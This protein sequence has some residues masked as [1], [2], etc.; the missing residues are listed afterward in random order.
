ARSREDIALVGG[1]VRDLLLDRTPRELDVVVATGASEQL[2]AELA[3]RLPGNDARTPEA[4]LHER[5]GTAVVEWVDGRIDVAE[6]RA[7][8]YPRPGALPE[9][10]PGT[11]AEDL[12]RRDFTVNA[13]AVALGGPRS[14]EVEAV[15]HALEDLA[16][17]R[18]RVLHERSFLDD[19]IRL[20][21]LAR[22][23][24]RLGFEVDPETALL[25]QRAIAAKAL[26]TVSGARV[27][28]ELWLA[29]EEANRGAAFTALGELGILESLSLPS[30]FDEQLLRDACS[31]L[32]PDATTS[33]L[34]MAVLFH[35]RAEPTDAARQAAARL[36]DSFEFF[37]DTRDRVLAGAF[38]APA[39]AAGMRRAERPSQL[40]AL[41]A[42]Q[43]VEAIAIAG[44][45][46]ARS[47]P[48]LLDRARAWLGE[49]RHV[50]LEI[51]GDE[52]LAAGVPEGPEVGRRLA[53]TLDLKLD[54]ELPDGRDAELRAAL[55]GGG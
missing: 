14:G 42:A 44:A 13:I 29:T 6:R 17:G 15:D 37:A 34:E 38:D 22:Y 12:E 51:G 45:L 33:I 39:L 2:A 49:L 18:L 52:L 16:A 35:P 28:A 27:A 47:S 25:A 55:E 1:A 19:P 40:R 53:R 43:P 31:L 41:L 20:L 36:M 8:S 5:F 7:E 9:V 3:S 24:A 46:G 23:H 48:E 11:A 54:G 4:K 50:R 30:R 26:G 21:R 32:P 10:R